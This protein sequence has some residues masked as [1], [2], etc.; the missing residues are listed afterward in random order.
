MLIKYV[1]E[2]NDGFR[3]PHPK[4]GDIENSI[5]FIKKED[6][7]ANKLELF[8]HVCCTFELIYKGNG[9]FL[10]DLKQ[11]KDKLI[12]KARDLEKKE[13]EVD[14]YDV[15]E[16]DDDT[17]SD[18]EEIVMISNTPVL[19]NN[20]EVKHQNPNEPVQTPNSP[21]IY[22]P[23][24][25][26]Q[27]QTTGEFVIY[28]QKTFSIPETPPSPIHFSSIDHSQMDNNI[29][30][31]ERN[32][33]SPIPNIIKKRKIAPV[34]TSYLEHKQKKDNKNRYEIIDL[35]ESLYPRVTE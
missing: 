29:N 27:T 32:L 2:L 5:E 34:F 15:E 11:I 3:G 12:Q 8:N 24:P 13:K 4:T 9:C 31:L 17:Y 21:A 33:M 6:D 28:T 20:Y 16:T 14:F 19:N 22:P 23:T 1:E 30:N 18:L 26:P 10:K 7:Y 35:T 25:F